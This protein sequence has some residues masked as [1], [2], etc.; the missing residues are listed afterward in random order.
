MDLLKN[1]Q[2]MTDYHKGIG[3]R[4]ELAYDDVEI[5]NIKF[6]GYDISYSWFTNTKFIECDFTNV[7]LDSTWLCNSI[8]EVCKLENNGFVKGNADGVGFK[9][10][11]LK[12]LKAFRSTFFGSKFENMSIFNSSFKYCG[13]LSEIVNVEFESTDLTGAS[14]DDS[15]FQNVVFRG[16]YF[17]DTTFRNVMSWNEINF[18]NSRIKID[19]EIKE[20]VGNEIKE[21]LE[22][23]IEQPILLDW[24]NL[25]SEVTYGNAFSEHGSH[26][27]IKDLMIKAKANKQQF[28]QWINDQQAAD[29]IAEIAQKRGV[30]TYDVTLPNDLPRRL[31]LA[32]GIQDRADMARIIVKED[33]SVQTAYP[34]NS[35]HPH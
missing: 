18:E 27:Q 4:Y 13:F 35:H 12:N 11:D 9:E 14:F 26:H 15:S 30:G 33:G 1:L 22:K 17:E 6:T 34:F 7:D 8:F 16:C 3:E 5:K 19:K 23:E 10:S 31:F 32:T 24:G 21:Y 20:I 28:G 2:K 29:F 25:G